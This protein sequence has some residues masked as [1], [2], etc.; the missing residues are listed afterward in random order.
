[1]KRRKVIVAQRSS[2]CRICKGLSAEQVAAVNEVIWPEPGV[3]VRNRDYRAAAVR[4]CAAVGLEVEVKSVTRH[5]THVERTWHEV[6][7]T[8]PQRP[9]EVPV[10]KTD[11]NSMVDAAATLGAQAMGELTDRLPD[12][13]PKELVAVAKLGVGAAVTRESLRLKAQ[14]VDQNAAI[15]T[16]LGAMAGGHITTGDMPESEIID[17]TPVEVLHAEVEAERASLKRL[18]AGEAP[19]A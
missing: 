9:G 13:D 10:F 12:L 16:A 6:T 2:S 17:V 11:F 8:Q 3:R 18:Q 7:G 4:A 1:M 19:G 15:I 5:A 14:E